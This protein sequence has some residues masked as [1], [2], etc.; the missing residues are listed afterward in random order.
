MLDRTADGRAFRM[1]TIVDGFARECLTIDGSR[2]MTSEDVMERLSDLFVRCGVPDRIRKD[3]G[4][5]VTA[6][7]V[8]RWL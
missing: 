8:R 3:N 7:R 5:Q 6:R 2:T 4:S 1:L